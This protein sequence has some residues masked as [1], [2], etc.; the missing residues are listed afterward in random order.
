MKILS[1][2]NSYRQPGGEDI[3][4]ELE[5]QL[6]RKHGQQ[7]I[8]YT[9]SNHELGSLTLSQKLLLPKRI[10]WASDTVRELRELIVKNRPDIAHVHNTFVMIS[11][12]AYYV[13]R[14]LGVPVVQSLHNPRLICPAASFYRNG[15]V[16]ESC[17][18]KSFAWP[19]V[20]HACYH[21]SR[22]ET[23]GVAAMVASHRLMGTWNRLVD[24]YIVFTE[25]YRNKFIEAGLPSDRISVKP[26]LWSLQVPSQR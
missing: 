8:K 22:L 14:E 26:H 16:C 12:A 17:L 11:P 7:V 20:L 5:G 9:R 1:V 3:V 23:A 18:G 10:I 2:Y 25:F 19:G 21:R 15:K 6:L 24:R 13:C 4:P